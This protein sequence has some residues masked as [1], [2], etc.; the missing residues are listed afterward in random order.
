M[1]LALLKN[2][3]ILFK[4]PCVSEVVLKILGKKSNFKVKSKV[5]DPFI[6]GIVSITFE[7]Y[8]A[9]YFQLKKHVFF[10]I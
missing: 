5:F 3:L 8:V 7:F 9:S 6:Y 10:K 4:R 2:V 1:V